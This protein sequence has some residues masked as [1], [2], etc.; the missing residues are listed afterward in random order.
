MNKIVNDIRYQSLFNHDFSVLSKG[1]EQLIHF[2]ASHHAKPIVRYKTIPIDNKGISGGEKVVVGID[3]LPTY[4]DGRVYLVPSFVLEA[5][6]DLYPEL[7]HHFNAPGRQV[8]GMDGK[9][10]YSDGL[11]K[12][13]KMDTLPK[14]KEDDVRCK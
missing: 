10:L 7:V 12:I 4:F 6:R 11:Y 8:R 13:R 2:Q 9:I 14:H 3:N 5:V 1:I